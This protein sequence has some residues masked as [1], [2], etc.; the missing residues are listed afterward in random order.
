MRYVASSKSGDIIVNSELEISSS[1][2]ALQKYVINAGKCVNMIL[3]AMRI[4]NV[5]TWRPLNMHGGVHRLK[6]NNAI[7]EATYI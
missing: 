2:N 3:V 6:I 5:I 1:N 7:I 4:S